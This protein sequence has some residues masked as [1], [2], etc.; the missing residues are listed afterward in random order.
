MYHLHCEKIIHK[1]LASR[2][3][4]LD[5]KMNAKVSDFGLSR[6]SSMVGEEIQS[7][8]EIGVCTKLNN[9]LNTLASKMDGSRK[10]N[11]EIVQ[12]QD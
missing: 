12:Q 7:K 10:S 1:D 11:Q 5:S 9:F 2:N 8:T 4:L 3:I 6:L